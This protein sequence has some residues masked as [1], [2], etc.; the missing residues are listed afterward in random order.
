MD[1]KQ[2]MKLMTITPKMAAEILERTAKAGVKNRNITQSTIEKYANAIKNGRWKLNSQ[3]IVLDENGCIID[4]QHRL[5]ACVLAGVPF[6]TYVAKGLNRDEVFDTIDCGRT[7]T[8][9]QL[10]AMQGRKYSRSISGIITGAAEIMSEG[11]TANHSRCISNQDGMEEYNRNQSHYDFAAEVGVPSVVYSRSMTPKLAGAIV[12]VLVH[13]LH[14]DPA[15]VKDFVTG[16]NSISTHSN[17]TI[18]S[19]R[20]WLARHS[21]TKI[22]ERIK[23]ANVINA[24]NAFATGTD[25]FTPGD[26]CRIDPMPKFVPMSK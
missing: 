2:K 8:L 16:I 3:T 24:W 23:L 18:D 5:S 19:V 9:S 14:Q 15:V 13:H 20:K 4:G 25:K 17:K 6:T 11:H 26:R 1:H 12:Y 7:R 22:S 10:L 21:H